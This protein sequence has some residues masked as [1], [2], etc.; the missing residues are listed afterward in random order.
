MIK[1][2]FARRNRAFLVSLL[3][4]VMLTGC[5][6]PGSDANKTSVAGGAMLPAKRYGVRDFFNNPEQAYFRLSEDGKTL[7]FMRPA[8]DLHGKRRNIYV[9]SLEGSKPTG[10]ERRLTQETARDIDIYFWKGSS[11][12]LYQKDFGGD[13][14][15]HVVSVDTVS[16]AIKD[17]T[18][19]EGTRASVLDALKDDPDH[20]LVT[21]NKRDKKV[22]D[23]VRVNVR[24]GAE[25]LVAQNPGNVDEWATDHAGKV[26]A[27]VVIDGTDTTVIYRKAESDPF[28]PII[29]TNFD[30]LPV[31]K[32]GDS[33]GAARCVASR[34]GGF[35]LHRAT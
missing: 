2:I 26:R 25:T 13:E 33:Y 1:M 6:A 16:G 31:L 23:V 12:L 20:I 7:A 32:D 22:F 17:L 9:Q 27:G 28:K 5:V 21:H 35:L 8:K 34:F 18:P 19:Y 10:V 4:T 15:Y 14:N 3:V 30:I 24:T 29:T 11:T